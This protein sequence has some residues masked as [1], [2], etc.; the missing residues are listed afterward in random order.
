MGSFKEYY[1]NGQVKLSGRFKENPTGNWDDIVGLG[2]SVPD[3]EWIYYNEH[4]KKSCIPEYW[5]DGYFIK[6][7]PE[8]GKTEIWK[9]DLTLNGESIEQK[10]LTPDQLKDLTITP[11]FKNQHP[12]VLS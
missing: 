12:T 1:S 10:T 5:E 3:G 2:F 9:V 6:Q 8:Q 7:I 4:G 11:R